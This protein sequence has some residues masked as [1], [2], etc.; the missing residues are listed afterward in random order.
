MRT[1]ALFWLTIACLLLAIDCF[2]FRPGKVDN[3]KFYDLLGVS[4][5][6]D[7]SEIKKAYKRLALQY[8][9]DKNP[10][11][12][13]E[14]KTKFLEIST[15]YEVLS[16]DEKR[17]RYDMY[18]EDGI[19]SNEGGGYNHAFDIFRDFFGDGAGG[20]RNRGPQKGP[21]TVI[22]K[23]VTLEQLYSGASIE[24][25]HNRQVVC[26]SCH[27][28]GA[29]SSKDVET[30]SSCRGAGAKIKNEMIMPGFYQQIQVPCDVCGGKGK[31]IKNACGTCKGAKVKR[32]STKIK[33]DIPKGAPEKHVISI[34]GKGDQNPDIMAGDLLLRITSKPHPLFKR[35]GPHL[36]MSQTLTLKEALFGFEKKIKYLDGSELVL[37]R[38]AVTQPGQ[39]IVMEHYGLPYSDRPAYHGHLYVQYQVVLPDTESKKGRESVLEELKKFHLEL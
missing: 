35:D 20:G 8:H 13:E 31:I 32:A 5:D 25:D 3:S 12:S 33:V 2:G 37:K 14:A 7:K 9:P 11:K 27:G 28:S 16:D 22:E 30:C 36:Y 19:D 6:C 17:K 21:D 39:V 24:I 18:G 29:K 10:D 1:T 4:K 26:E 23:S 38:S 15:A 34:D